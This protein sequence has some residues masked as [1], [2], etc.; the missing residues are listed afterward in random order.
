MDSFST[1]KPAQIIL[2]A[3]Q[4]TSEADITL[5]RQLVTTYPVVLKLDLILRIILTFLPESTEPVIYIDFLRDLST[6]QL[7]NDALY[8]GSIHSVL[9]IH[10]ATSRVRRLR[11]LP[12]ADP[13]FTH[14]VPTDPLTLFL[15]HRAR[16]IDDE[17]GSLLLVSQL[18][19]P[20]LGQS[21]HLRTWAISTLLPLLR[22]DYEYY[23]HNGL[24]Y[25]LA[26]LEVTSNKAAIDSLLS[27]AGKKGGPKSNIGRD[28]RGLVGPWMYGYN[29]RKRRKRKYA[30]A[31][32]SSGY[33]ADVPFEEGDDTVNYSAGDWSH[34]NDWLL[35]LA[36]RDY[37][38]AVAA[39]L[40]W[41]GPIDVDYGGW[42]ES[43]VRTEDANPETSDYAQT[44]LA[45][46]YASSHWSSETLQGS[47][48]V[49]Q[50]VAKFI[51]MYTIPELNIEHAGDLGDLDSDY[52]QRLSQADFLLNSLLRSDNLLTI[53]SKNSLQFCFLVLLSSA[54]LGNL[55]YQIGPKR[56][57][58]LTLFGGEAE[59]MAELR[60]ISHSLLTKP[61]DRE[62]WAQARN[63]MLWL[64]D[65]NSIIRDPGG[66]N[67]G[68][69]PG[70]FC[71]IDVVN[72]EIEML[73]V[74]LS[75]SRT[76]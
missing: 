72:L 66:Y 1:L 33:L 8:T 32:K 47:Y 57:A 62:Q 59:Q 63:Q 68:H 46:V 13:T 55:G 65:W 17:T 20:F 41:N 12:L 45:L 5:L 48:L 58:E 53:P 64:R 10:K 44:C 22:L 70:V 25:S 67:P 27:E 73:K 56:L 42:D 18:V 36:V 71:R 31:E 39:V 7:G 35:N 75:G 26:S 51:D 61:N 19:E 52:L 11:L 3:V 28:L 50:K 29:R 9:P 24:G 6:N 14:E 23:L 76:S 16:R 30:D 2:E 43:G 60:K 69:G 15:Q 21:A 40:Q 4:L 49:I 74:L 37:P 54:T 38:R 34:L